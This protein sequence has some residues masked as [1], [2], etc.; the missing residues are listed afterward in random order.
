MQVKVANLRSPEFK[1][2]LIR[3]VM[4]TGFV[5]VTHHGI[6]FG[7]IKEA[8][9]AWR[10][11][12][13]DDTAYKRNFINKENDNMGYRGMRSEQAVGAAKPDLKEFYHWKPGYEIPRIAQNPTTKMFYQ[14]EDVGLQILSILGKEHRAAC[15][16]SDNTLFRSLYYPAMDFST[17]PNAVRAAAHE[18]INHIT[19]L[20]AA[21]APGLQVKDVQGNWHDVPHEDNSVV[22]NIAD[23]LQLASGGLYKSTTHRVVNPENT[24][25]DRISM[26]LFIHPKG[27]TLLAQG[28]TAKQF[29]DERIAQIYGKSK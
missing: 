3:S 11:F 26:P 12:F 17:D 27:D 10:E 22:V 8:Q 16:N 20:V 13:T 9:Y 15:E 4:N 14:L 23:M 1:E 28:I 18:D 29:L 19:L 7:L 2:D 25:T 24:N 6:D 5:V 21:S